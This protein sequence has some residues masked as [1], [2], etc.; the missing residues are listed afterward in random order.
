MAV[1]IPISTSVANRIRDMI[2]MER[3]YSPKDKLP[4]EHELAEELQVSR[5]SIREAIKTLEAM[6]LLR[7]ERGRGTFVNNYPQTRDD[8]FGISY[9]ED[10]KKLVTHWF[11]MRLSI[12]P[13]MVRLACER[14]SEDEMQAIVASER[15][16]AVCIE[17]EQD[18]IRADQKFHAAIL[19]ATHNSV[20]ELML[21]TIA[22]A[23]E[24][25]LRT[26]LYAKLLECSRENALRNHHLI[27]IFMQQRDADGAALAMYC[28]LKRGMADI[29]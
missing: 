16:A 27:A 13:N 28:H 5:T 1:F 10:K 14:C 21:P 7:V 9:L 8:P 26:S 15:E 23:I 4:N 24:D 22:S 6:G 19:T 12:E 29:R 3:R 18:F 11:E 17:Q 20:I 25:T 2:L